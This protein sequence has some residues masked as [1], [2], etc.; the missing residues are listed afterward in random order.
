MSIAQCGVGQVQ[1]LQS[2]GLLQWYL[3]LRAQLLGMLV[4]GVLFTFIAEALILKVFAEAKVSRIHEYQ[5][6]K[7]AKDLNHSESLRGLIKLNKDSL[8]TFEG[9]WLYSLY[10]SSHPLLLECLSAIEFKPSEGA[11]KSGKESFSVYPKYFFNPRKNLLAKL[12]L[13]SF[14]LA[15]VFVASLEH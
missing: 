5:A 13:M 3:Q 2:G 6:D 14:R 1:R 9:D 11:V 15:V 12:N 8:T 7:F 4:S 10:Y